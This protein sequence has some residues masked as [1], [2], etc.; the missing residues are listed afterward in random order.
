MSD[1]A[2]G[3]ELRLIWKSNICIAYYGF[4]EYIGMKTIRE[5]AKIQYVI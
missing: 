4:L 5:L 1:L 2:L 3:Y